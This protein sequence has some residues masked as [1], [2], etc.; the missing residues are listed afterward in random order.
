MEY[1]VSTRVAQYDLQAFTNLEPGRKQAIVPLLNMRGKNLYDVE[2]FAEQ[3]GET[4]YL[5]DVSRFLADAKSELILQ[6]GLN[7]P[8]GHYAAK[9]RLFDE[10]RHFNG[11]MIPVVGWGS[12]DPSR[13]IVQ[14]MNGLLTDYERVAVRVSMQQEGSPLKLRMLLAAVPDPQRLIVIFDYESIERFGHPDLDPSGTLAILLRSCRDAGIG[15]MATLSTSYPVDKPAKGQ[16]RIVSCRDVYWQIAL[17]RQYPEYDLI[18]GDYGATDPN[19]AVEFVPG[20]S[21]LPFANYYSP[22][23]WWQKR[24]GEDK[25]FE[26]YVDLAREIR[27][28]PFY[29]SDGFCWATTE[30][31]RIAG[32]RENYGSNGKWNAYKINQHICAQLEFLQAISTVQAPDGDE[33]E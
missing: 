18:F 31:E 9:R 4:A 13:D 32:T 10:V 14:F 12:E 30:F 3:W 23:E 29:H 11:A 20:M 24:L 26:R 21:V 33:E 22:E 16:S 15:R 28:L 27:A 7:S 25:E 5:F 8:K 17:Q 1:I 2:K 6:S 19:A